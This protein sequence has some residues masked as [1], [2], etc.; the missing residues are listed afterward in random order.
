M[1][2]SIVK[3]GA[4]WSIVYRAPDPETGK[5]KQV[6]KGGFALKRDAELALKEIVGRVDSGTYTKPVK[7]TVHQW[8]VDH[9]LPSLAAR[10]TAGKLR[11]TTVAQYRTL[12]TVHVLNPE[13]GI[14]GRLLQGLSSADLDQLYGRLLSAGRR[15]GKGGLSGTTVH[16]VHV[17][18]SKM[19]KDAVDDGKVARNV[20]SKAKAV[21]QPDGA[22]MKPWAPE[23]MR[24]FL[25]HVVGDR[26]AAMWHLVATSG[27][28]RGEVAGLRWEFV[29]LDDATI[30][31]AK[32]RTV[33]DYKVVDSEP[34]TEKG[35]RTISLDPA[36]AAA[37]RAHRQRQLE[38]RMAWGAAW[39]DTGLV[40]TQEDG[41]AIHPE[42][43]TQA[44][45]RH[46]KVAGLPVIPL[47][48]L[49]HSYA[50]AALEAGADIKVLSARLGHSSIGIT[51]DIYQH[52]S[53]RLDQKV[54]DRVAS[55]ILG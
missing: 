48:G 26:L 3:R 53:Q 2:G 47:H 29:D 44:F 12:T 1:R 11:P 55:V 25:A 39:T 9:W 4:G 23:Q 19:L 14:G 10:V 37:L 34:K 31:I 22:E 42:R 30:R 46:A 32:T 41:T 28:R 50:T 36:T 27:L 16:A 7:M 6:W 38:E 24:A 45:Q 33:V 43:I 8:A 49:R 21:P 20:A 18:I 5:T 54:A 40:F 52:V 17:T 15:D 35:K 13:Y 51:G